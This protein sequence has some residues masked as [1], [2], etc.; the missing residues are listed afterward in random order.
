MPTYRL[1]DSQKS[2]RMIHCK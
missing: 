1:N 2:T